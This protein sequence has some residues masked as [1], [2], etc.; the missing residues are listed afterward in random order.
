MKKNKT[1]LGLI[2]VLTATFGGCRKDIPVFSTESS[3]YF[4][5]YS[6]KLGVTELIDTTQITFAFTQEIIKD[7]IVQVKTKITGLPSSQTRYITARIDQKESTAQEGIDFEPL[8]EKYPI[9]PGKV[10]IDI[11]IH[12]YRTKTLQQKDLLLVIKLEENEFFMLNMWNSLNVAK[13]KVSYT[14]HCIVFNDIISEPPTWSTKYYY[15]GQFSRKKLNLMS[16]LTGFA[17]SKLTGYLSVAQ[18]RYVGTV[19]KE[20]LDMMSAKDTPVLDEDKSLMVMGHY[21]I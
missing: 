15:W 2:F 7:S 5:M 1:Y 17:L 19:T 4:E 21:I 11:P 18:M 20:Y 16:E 6:P 3:V 9:D 13:E 14:Q 8:Q 10:E 12:L